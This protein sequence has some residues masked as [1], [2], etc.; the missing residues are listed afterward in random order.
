M[1]SRNVS[2]AGSANGVGPHV[3]AH[4]SK[5]FDRL[6]DL[7][8][9]AK[10]H[11]RP[12]KCSVAGCKY[13]TVG[14][15]TAKELERHNNDKHSA[16]PR[17]FPCH[18]PPCS[19]SSKRESNCKQHMEKAHNWV[20]VR[21][22]SKGKRLSTPDKIG[23][24]DTNPKDRSITVEADHSSSIAPG[25]PPSL[26]APPANVD[27]VLFDDDQA[28]AIGEDDDNLYPVYGEG[29]APESYL[30]WTSPMT[31]LRKNESFIE[32]FTQAYNGA[33]DKMTTG[34]GVN[35]A[36][37]DPILSDETL[38]DIQSHQPGADDGMLG[39]DVVVKVESPALAA[40]KFFPEKR[41]QGS[42]SGVSQGE[43][44]QHTVWTSAQQPF[45][46]RK[47]GAAQRTSGS[48]TPQAPPKRGGGFSGDSGRPNKKPRPSPPEDFTDT[49]MP[50][51]F[52][53]AHPHI[54]DRD[55][56]ER[57]ASCHTLH[58]DI[59]TLVRH[60]SRPAHRL[61]VTERSISSFDILDTALTHPRVGLC[62]FCWETFHDR[63]A[64]EAHISQPC[65]KVSKG[66][67]EK[68]RSLFDCFTPLVV[69][70]T[71]PSG[72]L[73][74]NG[75]EALSTHLSA[76]PTY[77]GVYDVGTPPTSVPSP[78]LD[79]GAVV[80]SKTSDG[81]FVSAEEYNRLQKEH[82]VL[83]ERTQQ[84]EWV[85]QM[86]L[87]R[88]LTQIA[89]QSKP[90]IKL[91]GSPPQINRPTTDRD[92]LVQHMDSQSTDVDVQG[93]MDEVDSTHRS[94]S[95]M[96]TGLSTASR[97][98]IH[99]VPPSPPPRPSEHSPVSG[100]A[101]APSSSHQ[102]RHR[103]S[104]H[105]YH[106]PPPPPSIPDSGY[107]TEQRRGSLS[108]AVPA[109]EG[110]DAAPAGLE[111]K[112]PA[113]LITPPSS[114][115]AQPKQAPS[116]TAAAAAAAVVGHSSHAAAVAEGAK[117]VER[118]SDG[119]GFL[120]AH[121]TAAEYDDES[122]GLLFGD[123]VPMMRGGVRQPSPTLLDFAGYEFPSSQ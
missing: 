78:V 99:H 82:Q 94:L 15:P 110:G 64:F 51:I 47:T 18:F 119:N 105:D 107:G 36:Q 74:G 28:D 93:L 116:T 68:W 50:D 34:N 35:E 104:T 123:S 111:P 57:Y 32:M 63:Q 5:A 22:K 54:Y 27:F 53:H 23:S 48:S 33:L 108:D 77:E 55:Q 106:Y 75:Y 58:R 81:R 112:P 79:T 52:R 3:C 71:D 102:P 4:C 98:T 10:S 66:K 89:Q 49:S 62:R 85:N 122:Y 69:P 87:A 30:P 43:P 72:D 8:K 1:A 2:G 21:S 44:R 37:V 13:V 17:T 115:D 7:N 19:Y 92:T 76:L 121:D 38:H 90:N 95:R 65:Q 96:N 73:E 100:R 46:K 114:F 29:Q 16:S 86:L 67:R 109:G 84:L 101:F 25:P 31:R 56:N 59:S 118:Q 97:S 70:E 6:C 9:H 113:P 42:H 120:S 60:L 41:N 61:K 40:D 83:W 26:L 103:S 88:Q 14:W 20:Y 24:C 117:D 91:Q 12:Y 80:S 45:D 39:A 11:S